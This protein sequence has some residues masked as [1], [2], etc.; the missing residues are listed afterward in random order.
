MAVY[1][2]ETGGRETAGVTRWLGRHPLFQE[3]H[4]RPVL[5]AL[6]LAWRWAAGSLLIL[7]AVWASWRIWAS[8]LAGVHA[9]GLLAFTPGSVLV[10][11]WQVVDALLGSYR[12]LEPPVLHAALGLTPLIVFAW[13]CAFA[14]GRGAVLRRFDPLLP[15]RPWLLAASEALRITVLLGSLLMSSGAVWI[16]TT[17]A[18]RGARIHVLPYMVFV[19]LF[20]WGHLWLTGRFR[21]AFAIAIAAGIVRN[22]TLPGALLHG[23]RLDKHHRAIPLRRAVGR[24]RMYLLLAGVAFAFVPAPFAL[25]WPLVVWWILFSLPPLAAADAWRLG[26]LF[27]AVRA[28][29]DEQAELAQSAQALN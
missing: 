24:V 19:P 11:P 12:I 13:V 25:G 7:L 16:S 14:W 1:P 2:A 26:A 23:W 5:L 9:T 22:L 6:E 28:L 3:I 17:L 15:R 27:A 4:R 8:S 20:V 18:F 21:R 10:E 29:Q